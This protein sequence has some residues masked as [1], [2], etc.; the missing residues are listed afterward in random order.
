[1][2]HVK[3]FFF[4]SVVPIDPGSTNFTRATALTHRYLR[5][6]SGVWVPFYQAETSSFSLAPTKLQQVPIILF[7]GM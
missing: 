5:A 6:E 2:W 4:W 7:F 3:K 1:M